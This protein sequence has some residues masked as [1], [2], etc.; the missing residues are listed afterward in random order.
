[1]IKLKAENKKQTA[2]VYFISFFAFLLLYNLIYVGKMHGWHI[3]DITYTY[4]LVDFKMGFVSSFLVGEIYHIIFGGRVDPTEVNTFNIVL[5]LLIFAFV[6]FMLAQLISLKEDKRDRK[7]LFILSM[8]FISGPYSFA[9][10]TRLLGTLDVYFVFLAVL[11]VMFLSNKV[12]RFLA[13]VFYVLAVLN[14]FSA[15]NTVIILFSLM[16]LY[17][18]VTE[19]KKADKRIYYCIFA[20]SIVIGAGAALYFFSHSESNLAYDIN[21]F[22]A[23]LGRRCA[24]N[25]TDMYYNIYYDYAIYHYFSHDGKNIY[26]IYPVEHFFPQLGGKLPAV[27]EGPLAEILS[28]MRYNYLYYYAN[29]MPVKI[30]I[31]TVLFLLALPVYIFFFGLWKRLIKQSKSK[32]ES[33]FYAL[34]IIQPAVTFLGGIVYSGDPPRWTAFALMIQFTLVFLAAKYSR[35]ALDYIREK[36]S[37]IRL[38]Y[39]VLYFILYSSVIYDPY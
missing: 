12:L 16:L 22:N 27:L 37:K 39:I 24:E 2:F 23:E 19:N 7:A 5:L 33:L 6:S 30:G 36:L 10:Y 20:A 31:I 11:F 29:N 14:H 26:G 3:N 34:C 8:F 28:H 25:N 38:S 21:G 17:K 15:L 4:H 1:M 13:P 32:A 9:L 18:A 35:D